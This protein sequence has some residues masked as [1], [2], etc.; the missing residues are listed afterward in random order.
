MFFVV[1]VPHIF[2][3]I[4]G[5]ISVTLMITTSIAATWPGMS[6]IDFAH[7]STYMF[8]DTSFPPLPSH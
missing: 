3:D 6:Q 2:G 7:G 5:N 4:N 1:T 8:D